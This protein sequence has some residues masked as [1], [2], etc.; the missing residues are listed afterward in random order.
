MTV[1]DIRDGGKAFNERYDVTV[2]V[3]HLVVQDR[4]SQPIKIAGYCWPEEKTEHIERLKRI[5]WEQTP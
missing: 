2:G 3:I 5:V 4:E 1:I